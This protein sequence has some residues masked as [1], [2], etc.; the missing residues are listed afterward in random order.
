VRSEAGLDEARAQDWLG[1]A[2]RNKH[3]L[4]RETRELVWQGRTRA[5]GPLTTETPADALSTTTP[6]VS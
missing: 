4:G 6:A 5:Y 2:R 1:W 3:A